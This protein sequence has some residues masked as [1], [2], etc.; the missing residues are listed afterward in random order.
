MRFSPFVIF[1]LAPGDVNELRQHQ[2]TFPEQRQCAEDNEI[3]H[4]RLLVEQHARQ[5][6][7]VPHWEVEKTTGEGK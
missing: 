5:C 7:D 3:E 1:G 4:P 6:Y 2:L